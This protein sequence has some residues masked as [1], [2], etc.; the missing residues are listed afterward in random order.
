MAWVAPAMMAASAVMGAA[1]QQQAA[2]A[3]AQAADYNAK[4]TQMQGKAEAERLQR[5]SAREQGRLRAAIGK[6]GVT[7]A[8]TPLMV[9]AESEANA[10]LDILNTRWSTDRQVDLYKMQSKSAKTAGNIG[11]GSSL[12]SGAGRLFG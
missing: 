5:E 12:L 6:S 2:A 3:Q 10:E 11:A 8:G 9:M 4:T 1:G 7:T